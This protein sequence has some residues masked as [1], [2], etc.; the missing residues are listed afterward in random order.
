VILVELCFF[1]KCAMM[2]ITAITGSITQ[3]PMIA[4]D[5]IVESNNSAKIMTPATAS[6]SARYLYHCRSEEMRFRVMPNELMRG[7]AG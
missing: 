4:L 3:K 5:P 2:N 6:A 1:D 7:V